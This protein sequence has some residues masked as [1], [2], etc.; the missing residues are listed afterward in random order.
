M[1]LMSELLHFAKLN[2]HPHILL[3]LD[4]LKA[5]DMI[6]WS[7]IIK[8]LEHVGFGPNFI[9]FI[10]ASYASAT[11]AVRINGRLSPYIKN[12]R[13]VR[14][15]CPLSPLIFILALDPLGT[16]LENAKRTGAIIGVQIDPI[17][18]QGLHSFYADD[19]SLIVRDKMIFIERIQQIFQIFGRASGLYVDWSKTKAAYLSENIIPRRLLAL[20][21]TWENDSNATKLL[22]FPVAQSISTPRML[23]MVN[24]KLDAGLQKSRRNPTSLVAR[25]IISNHM[26]TASIWF[27]YTLWNGSMKDLRAIQKKVN[28]FIWAGQKLT[29]RHQVDSRTICA[30]TS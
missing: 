28:T 20:G 21:W 10:K 1:L 9:G 14:Q 25:K 22:G 18:Q 13:S 23:K 4:I 19:V 17:N 7:F 29:G 8:I 5:F 12:L 27:L 30:P 26:L 11:S 15:G 3:K 6:E 2:E 16:M 24:A